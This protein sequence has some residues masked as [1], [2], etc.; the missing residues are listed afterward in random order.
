MLEQ[1][2]RCITCYCNL[3]SK[4]FV[5]ALQKIVKDS[6]SED[7]IDP[8]KVVERTDKETENEVR[9]TLS[10]NDKNDAGTV[11]KLR[12]KRLSRHYLADE[13]RKENRDALLTAAA[14]HQQTKILVTGTIRGHF[15]LN[16]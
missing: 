3:S 14:Y 1:Y 4:Q 5:C 11:E 7:D 9:S 10:S 8:S 6:D 16:F 12:Y 15:L 13:V 2:L